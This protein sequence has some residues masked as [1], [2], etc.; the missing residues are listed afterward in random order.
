MLNTKEV[1][2]VINKGFFC[3]H[4]ICILLVEKKLIIPWPNPT[5]T[6]YFKPIALYCLREE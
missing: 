2:P 4:H 5:S 1:Q 3:V 6:Q